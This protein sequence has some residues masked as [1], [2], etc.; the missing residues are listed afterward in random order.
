[1]LGDRTLTRVNTRAHVCVC[2]C[3]CVCVLALEYSGIAMGVLR[4]GGGEGQY[5]KSY[6]RGCSSIFYSLIE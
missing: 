3:V 4:G 2:V 1:M 5:P 6:G